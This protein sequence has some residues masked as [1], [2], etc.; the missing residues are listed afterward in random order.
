ML[1]DHSAPCT[2][3]VEGLRRSARPEKNRVPEL[4][5]THIMNSFLLICIL[6]VVLAVNVSAFMP[7]AR[8]RSAANSKTAVAGKTFRSTTCKEVCAD[9]YSLNS[10]QAHEEFMN[11]WTD[12]RIRELIHT[13]LS[14]KA[15][16]VGR[17]RSPRPALAARRHPRVLLPRR[18]RLLPLK[19]G[20][21]LQLWRRAR[22]RSN[23]FLFLMMSSAQKTKTNH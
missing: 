22:A 8:F 7:H 4:T 3:A 14:A 20:A 2:V 18:R 1:V 21:N 17:R 15:M 13:I 11:Q 9:T 16:L 5:K 23:L 6:L 19:K 10:R 12:S